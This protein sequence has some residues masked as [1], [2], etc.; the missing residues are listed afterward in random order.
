MGV[1]LGP[2]GAIRSKRRFVSLQQST[3]KRKAL[4]QKCSLYVYIVRAEER[5][6]K[7][8]APSFN[9]NMDSNI[10]YKFHN[11]HKNASDFF[12]LLVF[13]HSS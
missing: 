9:S 10:C 11:A 4:V 6:N 3:Y 2:S 8:H 5:A 7:K 12:D 13:L 1:N